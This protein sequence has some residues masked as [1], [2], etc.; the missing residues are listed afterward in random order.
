MPKNSWTDDDINYLMNN[1]S[2]K[3]NYE[4]S[5]ILNKKIGTIKEYARRKGLV[6]EYDINESKRI[7][8]LNNLLKEIPEAY[9]WIG[10]IFADGTLSKTGRLTI[11][12]SW[13]NEHLEN[14]AKFVGGKVTKN[15]KS[16]SNKN[17]VGSRE[18][19]YRVSVS[20]INRYQNLYDKFNIVNNKT[21]FPPKLDFLN[22]DWKFL[23]FLI[24]FI[25]GDG[26]ITDKSI[27]IRNHINWNITHLTIQNFLY[28]FNIYS[29]VNIDTNGDS[30]IYISREFYPLLKNFINDNNIPVMIRKWN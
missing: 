3:T 14:F 10:F 22:D 1:Y 2:L 28:K 4:L 12:T 21:Y 13:D 19:F 17:Y 16:K 18:I 24:G 8:N 27:V 25:D 6:K 30:S 26:N 7:G 11:T 23:S 29:S 5:L 9:Y 15:K 20:D